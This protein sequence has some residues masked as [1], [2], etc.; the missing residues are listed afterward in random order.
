MEKIKMFVYK[1]YENRSN[2]IKR[3]QKLKFQRLCEK[4]LTQTTKPLKPPLNNTLTIQSVKN[5][6]KIQLSNAEETI[7]SLGLNYAVP[8]QDSRNDM[9][10]T[11]INIENRLRRIE[12]MNDEIKNNIRTTNWTQLNYGPN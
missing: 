10:N 6:S 3:T 4:K 12:T 5:I 2:D 1:T 9:F 11:V 7:L 8:R